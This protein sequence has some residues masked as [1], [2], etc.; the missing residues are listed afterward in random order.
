MKTL[1]SLTF[2][3]CSLSAQVIPGLSNPV[4]SGNMTCLTRLIPAGAPSVSDTSSQGD[5]TFKQFVS[6]ALG[7]YVTTD[8]SINNT[9]IVGTVVVTYRVSYAVRPGSIIQVRPYGT[10]EADFGV[11]PASA[12][13]PGT[14]SVFGDSTEP[15]LQ[16]CRMGFNLFLNSVNDSN[17]DPLRPIEFD[18]SAYQPSWHSRMSINFAG[19]FN[20]YSVGTRPNQFTYNGIT[21][22][23]HEASM[24]VSF[25]PTARPAQV[26]GIDLG[27]RRNQEDGVVVWSRGAVGP[28]DIG[29]L[30]MAEKPMFTSYYT[31][32]RING[33][34][35]V[36]VYGS[37]LVP[38]LADYSGKFV[39][40]SPAPWVTSTLLS[41]GN[42]LRTQMFIVDQTGVNASDYIDW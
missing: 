4:L 22:G 41:A 8:I 1:L 18:S 42:G 29:V 24:T 19:G 12:A 6:S 7:D 33:N 28:D 32:P 13:V 15:G 37:F 17:M 16:T 3:A 23:S 27:F 39:I 36:G 31:S 14:F 35:Y 38:I 40:K 30:V 10:I 21:Y 5:Y 2:L 34:I 11:S 9:D 25:H 26:T 20:L